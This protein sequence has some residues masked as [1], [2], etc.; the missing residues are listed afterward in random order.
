MTRLTR[1]ASV[2]LVSLAAPVGAADGVHGG[3]IYLDSRGEPISQL[4]V[5]VDKTTVVRPGFQVKRVSVGNPEIADVIVTSPSE[6][7]VVA[8]ASGETN[9]VLWDQTGKPQ[10]L[11]GVDV[12]RPKNRLETLLAK[13]LPGEDI[14]VDSSK[15][16]IVLSGTVSST[17]AMQNALA[18][19]ETMVAGDGA[20]QEAAEGEKSRDRVVNLMR[21]AGQHQVMID[22]AVAEMS[23]RLSRRLGTNFAATIGDAANNVQFFSFLNGLTSLGEDGEIL[24][25]DRI[26]LAGSVL[27]T[28]DGFGQLFME[29][30]EGEGLS[31][32]LAQPTVVARSGETANFL[33]GGEIP[34]PVAQG[35]AFDSITVIFKPFGISVQFTPTVLSKDQIHLQIAPE[36]S[37]PDFTL[38]SM[39][40]GFL[41]PAFRTRRASTGV[42][43]RDGESFAIAGL[44][45]DDI[46]ESVEKFP[47]LGDVPVLGALFRSSQFQREETELVL[48]VTP[49][50]VEPLGSK[51]PLPT[52]HFEPPRAAE[53]Y[54][55]GRL[56]GAAR[57]PASPASGDSAG[58]VG[59]VGYRVTPTDEL[60]GN[61]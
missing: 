9:V 35:G 41:V 36:V 13:H 25:T 60:G 26:N 4:S 33:V 7:S 51:P 2:L 47:V 16:S 43:L 57:A 3:V 27:N 31:K 28:G 24:L 20:E 22:V 48:V 19:A 12:G 46:V 54:L 59:P 56:E 38:G 1:L 32:I 6:I 15:G 23:R 58:M 17:Q 14:H 44:L 45:S 39:I 61:R 52:D 8:K 42:D 37:E 10:K 34:I 18:L 40:A 21:V 49:R 53:F 30:L 11:L 50:L 29:L 5:E 55:L